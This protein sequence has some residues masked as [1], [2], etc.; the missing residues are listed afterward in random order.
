MRTNSELL[1]QAGQPFAVAFL[2]HDRRFRGY[3]FRHGNPEE[4]SRQICFSWR[5]YC[6]SVITSADFLTMQHDS[7][8]I[9]TPPI[10]WPTR[11][12]LWAAIAA[13]TDESLLVVANAFKYSG[14]IAS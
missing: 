12:S 1:S 13:G 7:L 2:R 4:V 3:L 9:P 10:D 6:I 8:V 11:L 14:L 5:F